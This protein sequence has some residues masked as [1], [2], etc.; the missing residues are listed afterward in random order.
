METSSILW[1]LHRLRKK[2]L[3]PG[4]YFR[5]WPN[6]YSRRCFVTQQQVFLIFH[7]VYFTLITG[8]TIYKREILQLSKIYSVKDQRW[9]YGHQQLYESWSEC[10]KSQFGLIEIFNER[11]I[12]HQIL[13]LPTPYFFVTLRNE[14]G[15]HSPTFLPL[16]FFYGPL[17]ANPELLLEFAVFS[18]V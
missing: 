17:D 1:R 16:R 10:K 5:H 7:Q 9:F 13:D 6:I 4:H 3:L 12:T 11:Y 2:N 14:N 8:V 15:L 18:Y